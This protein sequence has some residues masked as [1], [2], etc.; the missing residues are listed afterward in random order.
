MAVRKAPLPGDTRIKVDVWSERDRLMVRVIDAATDEEIACWWD[1][2]ARGLVVDGFL[3]PRDWTRS[4]ESYL[5]HIGV[6]G[7]GGR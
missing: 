5:R 1:D 3:D 4:A 2:D 6:L 7:A